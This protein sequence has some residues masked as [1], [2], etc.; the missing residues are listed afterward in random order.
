MNQHLH[1][2]AH[3]LMHHALAFLAEKHQ[4]TPDIIAATIGLG[5]VKLRQQFVELVQVAAE[6][7]AAH[8]D[9]KHQAP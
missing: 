8:V 5:H 3:D 6:T 1:A 2:L 4:T 7:I 9:D